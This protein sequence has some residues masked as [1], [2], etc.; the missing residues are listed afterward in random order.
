MTDYAESHIRASKALAESLAWAALRDFDKAVAALDRAL[1]FAKGYR[2]AL[3]EHQE[4][5]ALLRKI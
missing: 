1:A 2:V 4:Q 3:L 5:P